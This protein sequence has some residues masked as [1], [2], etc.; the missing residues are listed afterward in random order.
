MQSKRPGRPFCFPRRRSFSQHASHSSFHPSVTRQ[1]WLPQVPLVWRRI[2]LCRA[3]SDQSHGGQVTELKFRSVPY[4][5]SAHET[6]TRTEAEIV[7]FFFSL[8]WCVLDDIHPVNAFYCCIAVTLNV[9]SS[10][11][12]CSSV[13]QMHSTTMPMPVR[14]EAFSTLAVSTNYLRI[15]GVTATS[16]SS[17]PSTRRMIIRKRTAQLSGLDV[18]IPVLV[19][20]GASRQSGGVRPIRPTAA[21]L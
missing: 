10:Q 6:H 13:N 12:C 9:C 8:R 11:Y 15:S 19:L 4:Q 21:K 20:C 5:A 18:Y 17:T 2:L 14:H 3:V 1:L 7:S 16:G